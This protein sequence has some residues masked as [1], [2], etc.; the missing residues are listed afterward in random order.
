M[1]AQGRCQET[2]GEDSFLASRYGVEYTI[3]MQEGG[4]H[5]WLQAAAGCKHLAACENHCPLQDLK[6]FCLCSHHDAHTDDLERSNGTDRF[7][8]DA[9]ISRKN[10][11]E[12]CKDSNV[13][14]P[15]FV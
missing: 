8:F 13:L 9:Q 7:H 12:Y 14:S 11:M 4:D 3:G 6:T 5:K 1:R 15:R 2:P 10:L